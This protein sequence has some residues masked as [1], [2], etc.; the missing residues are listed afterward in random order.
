MELAITCSVVL[1]EFSEAE[2]QRGKRHVLIQSSVNRDTNLKYKKFE[3]L[4]QLLIHLCFE[5]Y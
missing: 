4:L 1:T 3:K 5:F 2:F